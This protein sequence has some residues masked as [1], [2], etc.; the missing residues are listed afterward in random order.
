MN[1]KISRLSQEVAELREAV[2]RDMAAE[3]ERLRASGLAEIEKIKQAARAELAASD[4]AAQQQL[5]EVAASMAVERAGA[6]VKSS[7]MNDEVRAAIIPFVPR[8][9]L[10]RSPN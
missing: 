1:A 4:R 10:E 6:V 9:E 7:K 5:R 3:T 8:R 2:R